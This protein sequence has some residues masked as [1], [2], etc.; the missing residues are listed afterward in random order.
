M[1]P[2]IPPRVATWL[3][4]RFGRPYRRDALLGDLSEEYAHGRSRGWYWRQVVCALAAHWRS[5]S[6]RRL[7][8]MLGIV[9]WWSVLLVL[10]FAFV[11]PL[12]LFALDPS[13]YL[14][15]RRRRRLGR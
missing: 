2:S 6:W 7:P 1:K 13:L 3:L 8:V 14:L 5:A 11:W 10:T 4:Q 12:I 15:L 9:T